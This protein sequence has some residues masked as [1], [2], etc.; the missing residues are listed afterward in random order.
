V[1]IAPRSTQQFSARPQVI[2]RPDALVLIANVQAPELRL[3]SVQIAD[4]VEK[5]DAPGE[6]SSSFDG[7]PVVDLHKMPRRALHVA[8]TVLV[9]ISNTSDQ[10]VKVRPVLHGMMASDADP[11]PLV[12]TFL[13]L[14]GI[15]VVDSLTR[16]SIPH[17]SVVAEAIE[18]FKT[19][20]TNPNAYGRLSPGV[21]V[22]RSS[23]HGVAEVTWYSLWA[24]RLT[25]VQ[26]VSPRRHDLSLV[27]LRVRGRSQFTHP[28][29]LP[30]ELF[31]KPQRIYAGDSITVAQ[32]V[33]FLFENVSDPAEPREVEINLEFE[34]HSDAEQ[35]AIVLR[36]NADS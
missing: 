11:K 25:K 3:H 9:S 35:D 36:M 4:R 23:G 18:R 17:R 7:L 26:I 15:R 8:E 34:P 2:F 1:T 31:H 24:G 29:S 27:D 10:P 5:F 28:G 21:H 32:E 33:S 30:V 12:P 14:D 22:D 16:F 6:K 20:R 13:P 19:E